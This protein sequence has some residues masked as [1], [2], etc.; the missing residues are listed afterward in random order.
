MKLI[1]R[2][3]YLKILIDTIET[4]DIKVITGIR[5]C[6]K[7][8]LLEAF[9]E[10]LSKNDPSANIIYINLNLTDYEDL[11]EYHALNNY[12]NS[13]YQ[14]NKTNYLFIDEIQMCEG[15]EKAIISLH[16]SEKY[17]IYITGSNAFLLSSDLATLFTGRT[18]QIEVYPFS[19]AEFCQYFEPS[20]IQ[21]A[22]DDYIFIGGM[23]GT[24]PYKTE[25][26]RIS[27]LN[28]VYKTLILRDIVQKYKIRKPILIEKIS[29]FMM[30]NISN[31]TSARNI[32]KTISNTE[33]QANNAT[34]S[35]YLKYLC[36]AFAFYKIRKYDV[37]GKKYLTFHDKY[38]LCDHAFRYSL[39]G[40]R[41]MDFGR[42]IENIIAIELIRRGYTIYA[43]FLYGKEIDF[44]A[45]KH[46]QK[47]YIQVSE[48]IS[49]QET[50]KRELTPLKE[51]KDAYP[52][53]LLSRTLQPTYDID[54]IQIIDIA[55]WLRTTDSI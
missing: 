17:S 8:K 11:T 35:S 52:K 10:Y 29:D 2:E 44:V 33:L 41:N 21:K 19:F 51:I 28:E 27:Y 48:N 24:Y 53:I 36:N 4:P 54:G 7:S 23:A 34:I 25:K 45:L 47:L 37:K 20:N 30:D 9:I 43:G 31:I 15:F 18:F 55:N 6:G 3:N 40:T 42:V 38:Y 14:K 12:I 50:L 22:F 49:N 46:S 32:A 26:S 39:L 16:T 1:K 13:H 5:R